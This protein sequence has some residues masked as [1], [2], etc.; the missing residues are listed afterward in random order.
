M[1]Q[2]KHVTKDGGHKDFFFIWNCIIKFDIVSFDMHCCDWC[3]DN[4]NSKKME[5]NFTFLGWQANAI[6]DLFALR[7]YFVGL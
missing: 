5:Q 2:W 7:F 3:H 1:W 6:L 4:E